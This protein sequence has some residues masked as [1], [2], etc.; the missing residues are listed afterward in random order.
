M[1]Q[2]ID[3]PVGYD[4]GEKDDPSNPDLSGADTGGAPVD[5]TGPLELNAD[6]TSLSLTQAT[7]ILRTLGWRIRTTGERTQAIKAFQE[8][9]NLGPVLVVDGVLGPKTSAALTLSNLRHERNQPDISTHFSATEFRCKCGGVYSAC[10]RI[11]TKHVLIVQMEKYRA[12]IGRSVAVV[13]GCRCTGHNKAVGGATHSRHMVGDAADFAALHPPS[14]F[15]ARK[16]FNG[17]GYN[18]SNDLV[19]HGDEGP[20]RSWIYD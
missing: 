9:W 14:W 7:T 20:V 15:T 1:S 3:E 12:A 13:S 16:I 8:M 19:R 11:W 10:A 18:R 5:A 2:I 17:K 6:A 4:W